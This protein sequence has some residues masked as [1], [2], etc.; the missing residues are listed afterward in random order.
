[1]YL[2]LRLQYETALLKTRCIGLGEDASMPSKAL[3]RAVVR[4]SIFGW[5]V[6]LSVGVPGVLAQATAVNDAYQ[7]EINTPLTNAAPGVLGND[8]F[9]GNATAELVT[10]P[11]NGALTLRPD[12][13]FVYAPNLNFL[14]TDSFTYRVVPETG[15]PSSPVTV[16]ITVTFA[17][18][19]DSGY[20]TPFN[21]AF[22]VGAPGVLTAA[23]VLNSGP[24]NGTANLNPDGSFDYTP[25]PGFSGTDGFQYRANNGI[26]SNI[27]SVTITVKQ[28]A[29]NAS[30]DSY[31]VLADQTT[32]FPAPGVLANDT[33]S[34]T[35]TAGIETNPANGT[36][37]L[38]SD[39]SFDYTPTTGFTGTDTFTY[40]ATLVGGTPQDFDIATVSITVGGAVAVVANNDSYDAITAQPLTVPAAT[41]LLLNDT[42]S[43]QLTA[44]IQTAPSNGTVTLNANG[45]FVYTSDPA[46]TGTDSF[47]YRA[48]LTGSVPPQSDLATVFITVRTTAPAVPIATNDTYNNI[49]ASTVFS[50]AAPGVLL[51]DS[52]PTGTGQAATAQLVTAPGVGSV[53]LGP[54]GSF[55][56]TPPLGFFG[57]VTFQYRIL[58]GTNTSNTATVTLNYVTAVTP[59]VDLTA[60]AP[61]TALPTLIPLFIPGPTPVPQAVPNGGQLA[62]AV[63]APVPTD[64]TVVVNRDGVNVRL[65]PAIGAEVIGFVNAGYAAQVRA[66]SAD[67]QWV[68]VD[69]SGEEGWI[70]FPVITLLTGNL[71]S[72]PVEDPRTIPYGGFGCPRAGLTSST[73]GIS[74]ILRDSGVRVRSGPSRAYVV[75]AN[76]PRGTTFPILG[77]TFNN[78]WFQVNFNG[79]L[80]WVIAREVELQNANFTDAPVDGIIAD[81]LPISGPTSDSYLGT[82]RLLL[83]RL[84]IAQQSLDAVRQR[85][86]DAALTG[87]LACGNYPASP[88]DYAVANPLAAAFYDTIVPLVT[89]FNAAMANLRV[90]IDLLLQACTSGNSVVS[91]PQIQIALQAISNADGLFAALRQRLS[92][93]IPPDRPIG[94]EDCPFTFANQ[95]D[96][97]PRVRQGQLAVL[98]LNARNF[99]LGFCID[100]AAGQQLRVEAL[101]F[102]G[103]AQPVVSISPYDSPTNFIGVGRAAGDNAL[104]T[105][106]PITIDRTAVYLVVISDVDGAG[107]APL[108]SRVAVLVTDITGA[109]GGAFLAPGLS[110]DPATGQL[111]ANPNP[112]LNL[113]PPLPPSDPALSGTLTFV[114]PEN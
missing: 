52:I 114:N 72:I 113:P 45:S 2:Q 65:F 25:N 74:G 88:T 106:G 55:T 10:N 83:D 98:Q 108:D 93:L 62:S 17:T 56:Y 101:A 85:W 34:G 97:L 44:D 4:F 102:Q 59:V 91:Q 48:T 80:G 75:L 103:N 79:V 37:L 54:D 16:T 104:V 76:A 14:E 22:N 110:I 61:P 3:F 84:N 18:A 38:R 50:N 111:V 12:G 89:D 20:E 67:N 99:V 81:A 87:Q 8:T 94:P 53:V 70:G 28:G 86:T 60:A 33:P 13:S 112:S 90:P 29:V 47:V 41:G 15:S 71:D 105:V 49:P 46:F 95:T 35:L 78:A 23:Y 30:N 9:T 42:P 31:N 58:Q 63:C 73:S 68:K 57:T 1:L 69:F 7:T 19:D 109:A 24:T 6:L 40:R 5:L 107:S 27:A 36:V 32:A 43:G 100:A 11:A 96:I 77:R 66:R 21:A 64:V 92:Q 82:L 51:N 39:G 26:D